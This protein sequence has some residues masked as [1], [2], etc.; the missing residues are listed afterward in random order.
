[1]D[2]SVL[3]LTL[4]EE[5]N[6]YDCLKS[7]SWCDDIVVYD[8]FSTDQTVEIARNAGARVFQR[9]FDNYAAQRNAALNDVDYRHDWILMLDADERLT[10]QLKSEIWETLIKDNSNITLY[11]IRRKDFFLGKWLKRSSGYPT[12][13]GR[14]FRKGA[15]KVERE[16]NEDYHTEGKIGY[17]YK[18]LIHYPFNKGMAFWFEKHN[19]YS[20]MEAEAFI[21]EVSC[22]LKLKSVFASDPT[23]RR[24]CHKQL[25]YR[26]PCRPFIVFSYLYLFKLGFCDGYPGFIYCYLRAMYEVM[27]NLKV[28]ELRRKEQEF[29]V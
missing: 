1:M 24:K 22:S 8:S 5:I 25:A 28:K 19:R 15:V 3:I 14:L 23:T 12:W 26:L 7:V 27:I 20:S 29:L 9:R 21:K 6:L 11:R 2:I 16:V 13:F 17:L 10:E 18:H 4:N